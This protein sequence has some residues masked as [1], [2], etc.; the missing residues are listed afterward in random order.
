FRLLCPPVICRESPLHFMN[1]YYILFHVRLSVSSE[2]GL[3]F[4]MPP[5]YSIV[6]QES[7]GGSWHVPT[8]T[9]DDIEN[10]RQWVCATRASASVAPPSTKGSTPSTKGSN[11]SL[12]EKT[13]RKLKLSDSRS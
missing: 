12:A 4:H 8:V 9:G 1:Q 2:K 6:I 11:I 3:T 13:L 7:E 5:P 10:P